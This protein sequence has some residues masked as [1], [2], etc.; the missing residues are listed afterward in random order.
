MYRLLNSYYLPVFL[1]AGTELIT[2]CVLSTQATLN[3]FQVKEDV[4]T[5][6]LDQALS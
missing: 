5:L 2:S 4:I 1:G 3:N 6:P